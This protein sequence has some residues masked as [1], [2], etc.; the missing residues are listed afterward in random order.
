MFG[1]HFPVIGI[2]ILVCGIHIPGF[3]IHILVFGMHFP[4]LGIQVLGRIHIPGTHICADCRCAYS[5][6]KAGNQ[7]YI[8]LRN[9]VIQLETEKMYM[10]HNTEQM[11]VNLQFDIM[12]LLFGT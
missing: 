3:G 1:I 4:V 12:V 7:F 8:M 10:S 11:F 5:V 2:H 6:G 9:N